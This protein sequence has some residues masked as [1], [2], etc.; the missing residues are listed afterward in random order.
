[1]KH[2]TR[3]N[4]RDKKCDSCGEQAIDRFKG[5]FVCG[6]CLTADNNPLDVSQFTHRSSTMGACQE[7]ATRFGGIAPLRRQLDKAIKKYGIELSAS[8]DALGATL[9]KRNNQQKEMAK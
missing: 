5:K 1:V 4:L 8:E 6:D 9:R 7:N 3:S 2:P